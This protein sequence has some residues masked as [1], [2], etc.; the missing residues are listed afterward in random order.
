[1]KETIGVLALQG[2][3][4]EHG[5]HLRQCGIE[6]VYVKDP[7][8]LAPCRGLIIPGGESSCLRRLMKGF[9]LDSAIIDAVHSR[10]MRVWGTCAGAILCADEIIGETPCLSL[11]EASVERNLF[12]AQLASFTEDTAIPGVCDTPE[13][14]VFIRAPGIRRVWGKTHVLHVTRDIITAAENDDVLI[15]SFHPELS[16]SLSFHRYFASKCGVS[17]QNSP[18]QTWAPTSWMTLG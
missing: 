16:S 6:P 5:A 10:Q 3:F 2:G 7:D 17:I 9:A 15:T 14:F 12:G 4:R 18:D 11:I 13:R 8:D 1:M